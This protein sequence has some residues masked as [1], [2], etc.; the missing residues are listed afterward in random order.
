MKQMNKKK[1]Y[2]ENWE[3]FKRNDFDLHSIH[4]YRC[5]FIYFE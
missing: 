5:I 4:M 3:K 2:N 1:S